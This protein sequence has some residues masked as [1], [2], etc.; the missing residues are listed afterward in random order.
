MFSAVGQSEVTGV[1]QMKRS[2]M[3]GGKRFWGN[4]AG[5]GT[6]SIA[7]LLACGV[8]AAE[9][10]VQKAPQDPEQAL[11][12]G[13]ALRKAGSYR[14]AIAG[15]KRGQG[16]A[17]GM[18]GKLGVSLAWE[19]ARSYIDDH[20]FAQAVAACKAVGKI[21]EG[22]GPSHACLGEAHMMRM[23]ATEALPEAELAFK[24][25][26]GLYEAKVV[27]GRALGQ[28]GSVPD[29]EK[30]LR[31]AIGAEPG[32]PEAYYFL[33]EMLAAHQR[34]DA[35]IELLQKALTIDPKDPVIAFAL[36][37]MLPPA[38]AV[39]ALGVAVSIRPGFVEAWA[40]LSEAWLA[41]GSAN[42]AQGAAERALK[43]DA[44]QPD[45]HAVLA[46]LHLNAKH[47]DDAIKEARAA[48]EVLST[49]A[50]AK[51]TEA[52]ALAA[53]GQ[54]DLAID[55][56]QVAHGLARTDPVVLV[57]AARAC[58]GG[59]RETSAKSF[60]DRVVQLFPTWAPGW[61]VLGDV[62][63]KGRENARAKVAYERALGA[64]G[65]MDRA[66]IKRKI[67]ALK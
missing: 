28:A 27:Q 7:M 50:S 21:V 12:A 8:A 24:E 42:E 10:G 25:A 31:D 33:G 16:L 41:V 11:A 43:L 36:G 17:G 19:I 53:T 61:V 67:A 18:A 20:K 38:Q 49:Q 1:F 55:A 56:Y 13:T 29:A 52:D 23:R 26:A 35:G 30:V 2:N 37:R 63:A 66:E 5:L 57:N 45:A 48:L 65:P 22:K 39:K 62:L 9:P 60:A 6:G 44:R 3:R 40:R 64:E 58:L 46:R 51:L 34:R 4:V 47:Y 54:I 32:R 15:L 14:E 59:A